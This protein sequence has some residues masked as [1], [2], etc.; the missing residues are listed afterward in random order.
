MPTA[1]HRSP[2]KSALIHN[3]P[4]APPLRASPTPVI[5]CWDAVL[6]EKLRAAATQLRGVEPVTTPGFEF[7]EG[8]KATRAAFF[9]L[10]QWIARPI[11]IRVEG[12]HAFVFDDKAFLALFASI[13]V[14]LGI[15]FL[16]IIRDAPRTSRRKIRA[17][18]G[19]GAPTP[20]RL[21]GLLGPRRR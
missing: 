12:G 20:P 10:I 18:Q 19:Q 9:G 6:N 8:P 14:D 4:A 13:A 15:V 5:Y 17:G 1:L 21:S 7:L 2:A 11:G 16:T 3:A